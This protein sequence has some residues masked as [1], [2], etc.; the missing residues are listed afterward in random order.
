M[1]FKDKLQQ[2][3]TAFQTL[4]GKLKTKLI[5][6]KQTITQTTQKMNE[7]NQKLELQMKENMENEKVLD[8]LLKEFKDLEASL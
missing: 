6:D 7:A 1:A 2:V 5:T 8:Q 4:A 3:L